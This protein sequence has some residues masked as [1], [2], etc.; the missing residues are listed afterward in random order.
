MIRIIVQR[1]DAGTAAHVGGPV[2]T[3]Y[4]TFDIDHPALEEFLRGGDSLD[5]REVVG[6]E[7]PTTEPRHDP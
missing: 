1:T 6:S 2:M 3:T 7:I 4:R 5:V